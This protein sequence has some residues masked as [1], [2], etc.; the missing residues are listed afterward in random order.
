MPS[1]RWR[2]SV[3]RRG[4][5]HSRCAMCVR[6]LGVS[7]ASLWSMT[8]YNVMAQ[9]TPRLLL[10]SVQR[11]P[12]QLV[13]LYQYL[14]TMLALNLIFQL[15]VFNCSVELHDWA[16]HRVSPRILCGTPP[17][18]RSSYQTRR[19]SWEWVFTRNVRRRAA[20]Q[21]IMCEQTLRLLD[22]VVE[23]LSM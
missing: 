15:F 5:A 11:T 6:P 16:F 1:V 7:K 9:Q 19:I 18:R 17:A 13:G 4:R 20:P 21:H 10:A 12:R 8:S 3:R 2:E 14:L 23:Y 22:Y